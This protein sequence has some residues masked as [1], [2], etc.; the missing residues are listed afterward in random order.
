[1]LKK[2]QCFFQKKLSNQL[3]IWGKHKINHLQAALVKNQCLFIRN[4]STYLT[5][6]QLLLTLKKFYL[7]FKEKL[8]KYKKT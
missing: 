4:D 2:F 5:L 7:F 3:K 1:M 6:Q 8:S